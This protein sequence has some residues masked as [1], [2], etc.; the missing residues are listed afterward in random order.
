MKTCQRNSGGAAK[1]EKRASEWD[2]YIKER[3]VKRIR[4]CLRS[5]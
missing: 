2:M 4:G 1:E 3:L 5:G